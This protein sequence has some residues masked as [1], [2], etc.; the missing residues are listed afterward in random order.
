MKGRKSR[1]GETGAFNL[2]VVVRRQWNDSR[3]GRVDFNKIQDIRWSKV[4]GGIKARTPEPLLMGF[5]WCDEIEGE[6][7]HSCIH[8]QAPHSIKVCIVK[9][10]N[11]SIVYQWLKERASNKNVGGRIRKKGGN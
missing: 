3:Q 6:I 2:Q 11:N 4:S 9:K 10:D 7:G 8:G 5:V 1:C